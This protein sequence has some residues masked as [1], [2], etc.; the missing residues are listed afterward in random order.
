MLGNGLPEALSMR[1]VGAVEIG[2]LHEQYR[3]DCPLAYC[4]FGMPHRVID[5]C[6]NPLPAR[7]TFAT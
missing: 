3:V 2:K 7:E 1:A 4:I 6:D 5:R